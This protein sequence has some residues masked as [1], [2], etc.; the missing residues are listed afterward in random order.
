MDTSGHLYHDPTPEQIKEKK[1][2]RVDHPTSAQIKRGYVLARERCPCGSGKMAKNCCAKNL[3][4][5]DKG[6]PRGNRWGGPSL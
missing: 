1:L 2:V 5:L 3:R 4:E 6:T